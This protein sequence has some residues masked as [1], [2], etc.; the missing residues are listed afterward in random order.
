MGRYTRLDGV[1]LNGLREPWT[2]EKNDEYPQIS[3]GLE[4]NIWPAQFRI[5]PHGFRWLEGKDFDPEIKEM[6]GDLTIEEIKG[7]PTIVFWQ[8]TKED[9][10]RKFSHVHYKNYLGLGYNL[11]RPR[12]H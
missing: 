10:K 1:K 4:N 5:L 7:V 6:V 9:N 2:E 3:K 12:A 11:A 8:G